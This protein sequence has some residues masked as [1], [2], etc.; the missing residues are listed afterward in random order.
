MRARKDRHPGEWKVGANQAGSTLFVLPELVPETLRMAWSMMSLLEQPM[1]Q[2]LFAMFVVSEIHPFTDG[3]GRT[4]RL[5]MNAFLS[6]H[7]QCR[8]IIP[9]VFRDDYLLSLKAM[10]H[11]GDATA[12]MRAMGI[13]QVWASELNYDVDVPEM[14]RQLDECNAKQED[15]RVFRLLWPRTLR[16]VTGEPRPAPE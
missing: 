13:G 5:L 10:S 1:Q 4:S 3:N 11:Q 9:T 14:N 6:R 16:P 8:I 15:L 12:Y 2:A 7:E